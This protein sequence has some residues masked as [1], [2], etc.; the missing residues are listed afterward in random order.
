M[1]E[2]GGDTKIFQS[3]Q[4]HL[5]VASTGHGVFKGAQ[6]LGKTPEEREKES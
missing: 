5:A 3:L 1:E 6:K 2:K 4:R